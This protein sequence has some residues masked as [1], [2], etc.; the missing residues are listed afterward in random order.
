MLSS[1]VLRF[2][3]KRSL[4]TSVC[5]QGH[6]SVATP[7][8]TLPTY[9]DH[10]TIPLPEINYVAELTP[11]QN[12]LKEK[13]KGAWRSLSASEKVDLYRIKFN[14][15]Y[16]DMNKGSSEWK[17]VVGGTLFCIGFAAFIF[18]WQREYVFG[19]IPHTLSEEWIA[20]Q[21]K[22]ML[23]MRVNPIEGFSA[24]WDYDKNEWKK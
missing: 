16:A 23:D 22:R 24:K 11:E 10:R 9:Q 1:Q 4:S 13:E 7:A 18:M 12:S 3:G 6:G 19:E 14:N 17:S 15:T 20:M 21:T 5:L 2:V 8:Y